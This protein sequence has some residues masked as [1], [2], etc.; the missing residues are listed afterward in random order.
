MSG[1]QARISTWLECV[2]TCSYT[3]HSS[4]PC[5]T[6]TES[7]A[8]GYAIF[9]SQFLLPPPS[10]PPPPTL[11]SSPCLPVG[12][13]AAARNVIGPA[14]A[15]A[16]G[17]RVPG[18]ATGGVGVGGSGGR[19]PG[20]GSR[21]GER[22]L[23]ERHDGLQEY[24]LT[25]SVDDVM[26][27]DDADMALPDWLSGDAEGGRGRK[28]VDRT[29]AG[30]KGR[31]KRRASL[32]GGKVVGREREREWGDLAL[33]LTRAWRPTP[34]RRPRRGRRCAPRGRARGT[35]TRR[36]PRATGRGRRRRRRTARSRRACRR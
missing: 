8:S 25:R 28:G 13:E 23:R 27:G 34:A 14:V 6:P 36:R 18:G 1:P 35:Q 19:S 5:F 15:A 4:H 24:R 12:L 29:S 31:D 32:Q 3:L 7:L 9:L 2:Q 20:N 21:G 22:G 30:E 10:L 33:S 17:G 11:T 16:K 26:R